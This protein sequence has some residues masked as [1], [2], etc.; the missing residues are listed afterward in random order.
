MAKVIHSANDSGLMCLVD[1]EDYTYLSE[2]RWYIYPKRY[3][4]C[5]TLARDMHKL[6]AERMGLVGRIDHRNRDKL[7]NR[8]ENLRLA[9]QSQNMANFGPTSRNSS[10]YR[11][12]NRVHGRWAATLI[13]GEQKWRLGLFE[14]PEEAAVAYD[15]KAMEIH[16][17]FA[18]RNIDNP[19]EEVVNRARE[20]MASSKQHRGVSRFYGVSKKRLRW[21]AVVS[22]I[23]DSRAQHIGCFDTEEEAARAVDKALDLLG[24]TRKRN[25]PKALL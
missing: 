2:Y 1:D 19:A 5:F 17:E 11:G 7:D 13:H 14:T 16:G 20:R 12:V 15:I 21:R 23:G 4:H 22:G 8:R 3:A 18:Y 9:T 24:S 6:I 25:F 10:G